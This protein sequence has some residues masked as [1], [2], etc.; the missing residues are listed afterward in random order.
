MRPNL[1]LAAASATMLLAASCSI[2][3]DRIQCHQRPGRPLQTQPR[4]L[5]HRRMLFR[6][7]LSILFR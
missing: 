7:Q 2:K 6:L 1:S 3:E 4:H 5:P